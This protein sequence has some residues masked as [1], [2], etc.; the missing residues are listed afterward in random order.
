MALFFN[1]L[2]KMMLIADGLDANPLKVVICD[3]CISPT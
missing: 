1:D 2:L 3:H